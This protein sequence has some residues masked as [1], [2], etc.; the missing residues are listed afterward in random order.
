MIIDFKTLK[1]KVGI[2]DVAY[3]LGYRVDK[4]AGL[5]RYIEMVSPEGDKIV[6]KNPHDKVHQTYFRHNGQKG[7]DVISFVMEH[8]NDFHHRATNQWEAVTEILADISNTYIDESRKYL[9]S[10]GYKGAQPFVPSRYDVKSVTADL[11]RVQQMLGARGITLET[12]RAFGDKVVLLK[13]NYNKVYTQYN[14]AFPYTRP[15]T[16]QV[17]GYEIRG[18]AGYKSKAAGTDS[19]TAAWIVDLSS[20]KNPLNKQ[21]VFFAESAYDVMAFWQHNKSQIDKES[22]VFVSIGGTFSDQQ[23][24]AIMHHY[25]NATAVDCYDNDLAGRVYGV[26]MLALLNG[27]KFESSSSE[28]LL[29]VKLN[30]VEKVYQEKD[31]TP[32]KVA[33]DYKLSTKVSR[34]KAPQKY[35]DWND[36]V[37]NKPIQQK[38]KY[39]QVQH[40][41]QSR[42][43][44]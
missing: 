8:L 20:D 22:S 6:V 10:V 44:R 2:D 37:Q 43:K 38:S 26:R 11:E 39:E 25:G 9:D 12:V 27:A 16:G 33:S 34:W 32:A 41:Q 4:R 29:H 13:D 31:L 7:G 19:S 40:L 1:A 18:F 21:H 30:G 15:Q 3:K 28:G 17:V 23:I 36:V 14:V 42:L 24:K 35:K 5:G